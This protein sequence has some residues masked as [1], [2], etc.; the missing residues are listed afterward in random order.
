MTEATRAEVE[1]HR[2]CARGAIQLKNEIGYNPTRFSQMVADTAGARPYDCSSREGT[3]RMG[4]RLC[5]KPAVL[6]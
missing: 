2:E 6:R 3:R 4:S 5:G 1:F